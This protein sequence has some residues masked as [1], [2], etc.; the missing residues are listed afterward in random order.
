[1]AKVVKRRVTE[2][3]KAAFEGID[4]FVVVDTTGFAAHNAEEFRTELRDNGCRMLVVKN[5][6]A[7]RALEDLG[8]PGLDEQLQGQSAILI[9]DE[10]ALAVSKL[11]V[12]WNKK[13]K[14]LGIRGGYVDGRVIDPTEVD[15]LSKIPDRPVLLSMLLAGLHGPMQK[16]HHA[17]SDPIRRF[18]A[19][20]DALAEKKKE[21]EG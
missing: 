1:M 17:V 14:L 15:R 18:A 20:V 13:N 4:G 19:L 3:L 2:E 16:L 12:P 9:G 6:L 5:S 8:F 10:G 7:R 11:L 21:S